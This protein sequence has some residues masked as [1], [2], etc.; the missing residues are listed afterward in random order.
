MD[1]MNA[2]TMALG[3]NPNTK[4][5]GFGPGAGLAGAIMAN[6]GAQLA[7][8]AEAARQQDL[9]MYRGGPVLQS[10]G[11]LVLNY[12][13]SLWAFSPGYPTYLEAII[14]CADYWR[15]LGDINT[16]LAAAKAACGAGDIRSDTMTSVADHLKAGN[17]G[18]LSANVA[19]TA[20]AAQVATQAREAAMIQLRQFLFQL[21]RQS[22]KLQWNLNRVEYATRHLV[23]GADGHSH[24][25]T[26]WNVKYSVEITIEGGPAALPA[27]AGTAAFTCLMPPDAIRDPGPPPGVVSPTAP[28]F[29]HGM[30]FAAGSPR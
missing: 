11:K 17:V 23:T 29:V 2:Q 6:V 27:A 26:R 16:T 21:N 12:V 28:A 4:A 18:A 13:E 15:V 1:R 20:A 25:E 30:G 19:Q 14:P 3:G 10:D 24:Y 5:K 7:T 8:A 9:Q 22:T